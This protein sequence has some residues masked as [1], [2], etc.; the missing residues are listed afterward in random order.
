MLTSAVIRS[1]FIPRQ[2][3]ELNTLNTRAMT[4][5][6]RL[7]GIFVEK[8]PDGQAYRE[9]HAPEMQAT[10]TLKLEGTQPDEMTIFDGFSLRVHK[11]TYAIR[12]KWTEEVR[13]YQQV[14]KMGE[15]TKAMGMA[16]SNTVVALAITL[17]EYGHTTSGI[18]LVKGV[19]LVNTRAIDKNPIFYTAHTYLNNPGVTMSNYLATG[20]VDEA[21]INSITDAPFAWRDINGT[22]L[23]IRVR[24]LFGPAAQRAN[25]YKYLGSEYQPETGNNTINSVRQDLGPTDFVIINDLTDPD[26]VYG[27]TDSPNQP[28][29]TWGW[30][31]DNYKG[32]DDNILADMV[33][34]TFSLSV[35]AADWTGLITMGD[36]TN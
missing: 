21:G 13:K 10:A 23:N 7:K 36:R 6:E 14:D 22:P 25:L 26:V 31:P 2:I 27:V 29:I 3:E 30:K 8:R 20:S 4:K 11:R 32:F 18:P 5:T 35:D 28:Q 12:A 34:T 1:A 24:R 17:L 33:T 15:I 9:I 19:Q 16:P